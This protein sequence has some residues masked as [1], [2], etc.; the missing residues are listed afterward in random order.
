MDESVHRQGG[1]GLRIT[2]SQVRSFVTVASTNSF[3]RAAEV[4]NLSQPALT[5]RIPQL[6]ES[7]ELRCSTETPAITQQGIKPLVQTRALPLASKTSAAQADAL[8]ELPSGWGAVVKEVAQREGLVATASSAAGTPLFSALT[9]Q[10][11]ICPSSWSHVGYACG[12]CN[13][14]DS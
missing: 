10:G 11:E 12:G 2:F 14:S 4:L 7:L 6:E 5:G 8:D 1:Q 9:P 3:T 13:F